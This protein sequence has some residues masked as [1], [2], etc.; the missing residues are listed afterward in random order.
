MPQTPSFDTDH[1]GHSRWLTIHIANG[2]LQGW[3]QESAPDVV[4]FM[5]GTNDIQN[6]KT[7]DAIIEAYTTMVDLMRQANPN[8]KIIV[9]SEVPWIRRWC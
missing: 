9:S 1:E 5:L 2:W 3:L 7:T 4:Q 6:G 8:V